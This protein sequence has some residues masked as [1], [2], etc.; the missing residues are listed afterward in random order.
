MSG[1]TV[2]TSRALSSVTGMASPVTVT[3]EP[4]SSR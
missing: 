2:S 1:G 3:A 4:I